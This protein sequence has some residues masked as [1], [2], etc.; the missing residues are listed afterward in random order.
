MGILNMTQSYFHTDR[1]FHI[2]SPQGNHRGW[3]FETRDDM[4]HG[5]YMTVTLAEIALA[6]YLGGFANAQ[7]YPGREGD[8]EA[9]LRARR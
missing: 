4:P 3:Y 6:T 1:I 5:P 9:Y 8:A 2:D 7:K